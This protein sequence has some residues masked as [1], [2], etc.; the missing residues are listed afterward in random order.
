METISIKTQDGLKLSCL[1]WDAAGQRS[2]LLLHM[3][4]ATKE[5]WLGLGE[6]LN[7]AGLNVL[8]LDF[9]GHGASEGGDYRTFAPEQHQRYQQ[10]V[11]AGWGFLRERYP[12]APVRLCGASIGANFTVRWLAEHPE[13]QAGVALSAGLDYYGV[14]AVD[15]VPRIGANQKV[16]YVGSYDDGR[17][18]GDNCGQMARELHSQ[19]GG[20]KELVTYETG[21]HGT[22]LFSSHPEL[23]GRVADF[24]R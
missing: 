9:R 1:W 3:M 6:R 5:S 7:E 14:R 12:A 18:S 21:G 2:V 16:L 15:F 8:A 4:P 17:R 19:S 13:I 22:E 24:L 10:D 23:L 11:E 20:Q